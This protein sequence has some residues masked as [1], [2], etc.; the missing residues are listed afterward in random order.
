MYTNRIGNSTQ[1]NNQLINNNHHHQESHQSIA[2]Q[3]QNNN[4]FGGQMHFQNENNNNNN[5]F[6]PQKNHVPSF[7]VN[8]EYF[9][10]LNGKMNNQRHEDNSSKYKDE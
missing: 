2:A 4:N 3:F 6:S 8:R 1:F 5:N 9:T 7:P 10:F